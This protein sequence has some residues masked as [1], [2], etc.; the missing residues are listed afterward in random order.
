M[1]H[2]TCGTRLDASSRPKMHPTHFLERAHN[3]RASE[4]A[5][6]AGVK[7][8]VGRGWAAFTIPISPKSCSKKA[9]PDYVL[10]GAAGPLPTATSSTKSVKDALR[11]SAPALR[12][13]F[14]LDGSQARLPSPR[15]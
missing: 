3:A 15:K 4:L 5:K 2:M 1:L 10:T 7:I 8:P 12:C 13:D 11:T 9:R 6:K 14:C